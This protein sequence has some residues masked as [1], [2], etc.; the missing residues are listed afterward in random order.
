MKRFKQACRERNRNRV[1]RLRRGTLL[2]IAFFLQIIQRCSED[3]SVVTWGDADWGGDST[4][5]QDQLYMV[6][7]VCGTSRAFL[8][9]RSNGTFFLGDDASW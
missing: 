8:E 6:A 9:L 3:G 7:F 5:V 4:A 2:S 1:R